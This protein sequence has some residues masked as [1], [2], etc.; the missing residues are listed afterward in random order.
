M[1]NKVIASEHLRF[2]ATMVPREVRVPGSPEYSPLEWFHIFDTHSTVKS[3]ILTLW[4]P[5]LVYQASQ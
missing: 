1:T 4:I 2:K 3:K 5:E